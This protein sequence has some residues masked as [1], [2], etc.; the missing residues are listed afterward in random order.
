[1]SDPSLVIEKKK[2]TSKKIK[3]PKKYKVVVFNDNVTTVEFVIAML[4][5]VFD[6]DQETAIQITQHV[7]ES[8]SGV[9][10]TY[11]Y[12][13]AEQKCYEGV[14]LSRNNGFPL[15]LKIVEE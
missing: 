5:A 4:I 11:A 9:A 8:G 15:V 2:S 14:E 3:P 1:M 12:E 13:I 10:G 7:H 6:R